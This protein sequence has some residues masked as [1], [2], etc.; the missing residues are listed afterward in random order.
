[1]DSSIVD[2]EHAKQAIRGNG[3][4]LT[5]SSFARPKNDT[6]FNGKYYKTYQT[7]EKTKPNLSVKTKRTSLP[8]DSGAAGTCL[9]ACQPMGL[10]KMT[11]SVAW[12]N[13]S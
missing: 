6:G 9:N 2:T 13:A 11:V 3:E 12:Q 4:L 10:E 5:Q 1:M 8:G 7:T